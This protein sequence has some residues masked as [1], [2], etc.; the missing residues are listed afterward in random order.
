APPNY[1]RAQRVEIAAAYSGFKLTKAKY[2]PGKTDSTLVKKGF[3]AGCLPA[4]E[5]GK[6]QL[7]EANAIAQFVANEQL[8]GGSG[9]SA[10]VAQFANWSDATFVPPMTAWVLP[11]LGVTRP[12]AGQIEAAKAQVAAGLKFLDSYLATRT[13]LV[14]ERITLADVAVA[15]DLLP[16]F[17]HAMGPEQRRPYANVSRWFNTLVNQPEFKRILGE[18][19]LADK[20]GEFSQARYDQLRQQSGGK[21][22]DKKQAKKEEP[23]K[24]EAAPKKEEPKKEATATAAD[25]SEKKKEDK[26]PFAKLPVGTFNMDEFKRVYS[27]QDIKT[28][29]IPYFW[30]NFD[31]EHY[32]LWYCEYLYPE[33]LRLLFMS[34]NLIGGMFQR[35]ERMHKHAFGSMVVFGENNKSTISGLWFWRGQ[36]LAF[37]LSEDL[38]VDYESYSWRKLDPKSD[39]A[40]KLVEA[41][42]L[43]DEGD[44]GDKKFARG[45]IFK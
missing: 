37:E 5:S 10:N 9:N 17:Q 16:L 1:F 41:Y 38:Q 8:R 21:K 19:K 25:E 4:F 22:D 23:K 40:K 28:V 20:A 44:F 36:G 39:E 34:S 11:C 15:C 32:S 31:P 13:Y 14:G 12:D 42:F 7:F 26:D 6:E 43:H 2:E 18:V 29:A 27:N 24:K 3:P 35:L 45:K 33:D 30:Q